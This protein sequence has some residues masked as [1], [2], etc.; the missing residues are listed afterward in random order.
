MTTYEDMADWPM[1]EVARHTAVAWV[2][3]HPPPDPWTLRLAD[4]WAVLTGRAVAVR[5]ATL[6]DAER[7]HRLLRRRRHREGPQ[8][9]PGTIFSTRDEGQTLG[10]PDGP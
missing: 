2:K 5:Q 9:A 10:T 8:R 6:A 3:H 1:T 7:L 4:A